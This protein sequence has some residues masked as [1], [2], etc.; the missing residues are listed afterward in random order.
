MKDDFKEISV[1]SKDITVLEQHEISSMLHEI[2]EPTFIDVEFE[3]VYEYNQVMDDLK[4]KDKIE[5]SA[6]ALSTIGGGAFGVA[7]A[8]TLASA[9]GAS[10]LLGSTSLASVLGGVF[11]TTTPVGWV[12]GATVAAGAAGY[13]ISKL[14]KSGNKVKKRNEVIKQLEA[15]ITDLKSNGLNELHL[16]E[17]HQLLLLAIE[18]DLI[19]DLKIENIVSQI[20]NGSLKVEIAVQRIKLLLK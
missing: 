20:E 4:G 9:A 6:E 13:G 19:S 11:V 18:K 16:S 12:V 15:R 3:K 8:G 5:I 14:F 17:L 7:A 2:D 1:S 10:T